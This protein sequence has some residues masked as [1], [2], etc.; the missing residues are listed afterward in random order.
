MSEVHMRR[1]ADD[2]YMD[3]LNLVN[4]LVQSHQHTI[5][6]MQFTSE[7]SGMSLPFISQN[8]QISILF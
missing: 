5:S 1:T 6:A 7:S 3:L 2:L 8:S 4:S